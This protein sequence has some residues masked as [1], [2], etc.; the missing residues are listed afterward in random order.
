MIDRA[1]KKS[2]IIN[3]FSADVWKHLTDPDSIKKFLFDADV[4]TD[5][6]K[7]HPIEFRGNWKGRD[8][9][10]K[11]EILGIEK[12]KRLEH[13]YYSNLSEK[14][15]SP[16]NYCRIIYELEDNEN[17]A[18]V[19]VTQTDIASQDE[20]DRVAEYWQ[21]VLEKLKAVV[22]KEIAANQVVS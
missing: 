19:S 8:Y 13:S 15:D 1:V 11:G 2:I 3:A 17:Q 4:K 9:E 7:G 12:E 18:V 6:K 5:W 14:T 10:G 16:E 21:M 22:E 20:Y